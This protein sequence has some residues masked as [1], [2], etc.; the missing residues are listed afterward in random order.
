MNWPSLLI[1][2]KDKHLQVACPCCWFRIW[3]HASL[4]TVGYPWMNFGLEASKERVCATQIWRVGS[5]LYQHYSYFCS[6]ETCAEC[7][8]PVVKLEFSWSKLLKEWL[9]R[10]DL[11]HCK[12]SFE[13]LNATNGILP[14]HS[15]ITCAV[16]NH[17][18]MFYSLWPYRL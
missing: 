3:L 9:S 17:S 2:V 4:S 8:L 15:S 12:Y 11:E 1:N 13:P 18:V 16:L 6:K 5:S 10:Q 7:P 14:P